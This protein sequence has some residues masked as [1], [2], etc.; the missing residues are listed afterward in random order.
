MLNF[1]NMRIV[2]AVLFQTEGRTDVR[3]HRYDKTISRFS[4]F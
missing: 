1:M 4:E 3:M 2:G